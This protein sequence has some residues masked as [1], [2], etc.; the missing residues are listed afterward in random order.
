[1]KHGYALLLLGGLATPA[2]L[3]AQTIQGVVLEMESRSPV[4]GATV[5]LTSSRGAQR[6]RADSLGA[7]QLFPRRTGM[8]RI[9]VS[10]PSYIAAG[11]TVTLGA[12]ETLWLELRLQRTAIPLEPLVV[13]ARARD[14]YGGFYARRERGG[15]GQFVTREQVEVRRTAKATELL[16]S[17]PGVYITR[18]QVAPGVFSNL[19]TTR[20]SGRGY[21]VPMVYIDGMPIR[22]IAENSVDDIIRANMI[23][24]VE[25]YPS[26]AGVPPQFQTFDACGVVAFWTRMDTRGH[27]SWWKLGAGL[28]GFLL[29]VGLTHL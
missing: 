5:E 18:M 28:G 26:P 3:A 24:G 21:C 19:I 2:W 4:A 29:A 17:M 9:R 14:P 11:D 23:E 20:G 15:F 12:E 1:M 16:E 25:V 13:K 10:H 27:W 22:Q 6:A 8:V 7:F